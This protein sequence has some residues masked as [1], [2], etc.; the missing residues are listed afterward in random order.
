MVNATTISAANAVPDAKRP[1]FT[2]LGIPNGIP[3]AGLTPFF[4]APREKVIQQKLKDQRHEIS[5]INISTYFNIISMSLLS[6]SW[7]NQMHPPNGRGHRKWWC[8]LRIGPLLRAHHRHGAYCLACWG[9]LNRE[10]SWEKQTK[11]GK[12]S[13]QNGKIWE[14]DGNM[15]EQWWSLFGFCLRH[16]VLSKKKTTRRQQIWPDVCNAVSLGSEF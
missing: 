9:R 15:N 2:V 4:G 11:M 3:R 1:T 13:K 6:K 5:V 12:W 8:P 14:N 10:L 16:R 7:S